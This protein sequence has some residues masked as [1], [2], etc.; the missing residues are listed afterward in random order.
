[1]SQV[2]LTKRHTASCPFAST[3]VLLS[4][5]TSVKVNV[6]TFSAGIAPLSDSV[7]YCNNRIM[8]KNRVEGEYLAYFSCSKHC[9]LHGDSVETTA[10]CS[11]SSLAVELILQQ[12]AKWFI[13]LLS[14]PLLGSHSPT[15]CIPR[16]C[17]NSS[18]SPESEIEGVPMT[19]GVGTA[20]TENTM[21]E[22]KG[23][24]SIFA[25]DTSFSEEKKETQIGL[26]IRNNFSID[27]DK[28]S[29]VPF[30][31]HATKTTPSSRNIY[32][33]PTTCGI[34]YTWY[35]ILSALAY[36]QVSRTLARS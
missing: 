2:S 14:T 10:C 31:S 21:V 16:W 7:S 19:V 12:T 4:S 35:S 23:T 32:R 17:L 8:R 29:R 24:A 28:R 30:T 26:G 3:A 20:N 11:F 1:V 18:S 22:F 25:N 6:K 5:K 34:F 9:N 27:S 13:C 36:C 15:R 33:V